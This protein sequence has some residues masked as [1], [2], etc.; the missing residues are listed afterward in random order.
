MQKILGIVLGISF[1]FSLLVCF[2]KLAG[3]KVG[4]TLPFLNAQQSTVETKVIAGE[5][6]QPQLAKVS[7]TD[8]SN[9][10]QKDSRT[11]G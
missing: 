1:A 10:K 11:R 5:G 8:N 2:Y 7:T 6:S 4:I 3:D 9:V